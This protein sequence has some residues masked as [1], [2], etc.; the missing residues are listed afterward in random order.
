MPRFENMQSCRHAW[1]IFLS[2]HVKIISW[3]KYHINFPVFLNNFVEFRKRH[4]YNYQK[5]QK[6]LILTAWLHDNSCSCTFFFFLKVVQNDHIKD[7]MKFFPPKFWYC[8]LGTMVK[9]M[10]NHT[11]ACTVMQSCMIFWQRK[12]P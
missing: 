2:W 12:C 9:M 1:L 8:E 11:M 5:R 6:C 4:W 3:R 10:N 7:I